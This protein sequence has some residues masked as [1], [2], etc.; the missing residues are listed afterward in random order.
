MK[1]PVFILL[2]TQSII[3]GMLKGTGRALS[4]AMMLLV[5]FFGFIIQSFSQGT[6]TF[7]SSG[8][9][10][11]P[12]GVF[13]ATVETWGGGGGGS[14]SSGSAGGGGGGGAYTKGLLTGLSAGNSISI[15]V[16]AAGAAGSPTA[17]PGN[18][19]SAT[20]GTNSIT[21]NG[22]LSVNNSRN[23]GAGG[24][25]SAVGGIIIASYAGGAGGDGR[26]FLG[27][28]EAGGGGGGSAFTNA[29]GNSG[30]NGGSS[31]NKLTPGGTGTGNGGGG[32]AYDGS[33]DAVAG[34][35]PGGGGGGRGSGG[36]TS[37]AGAAGRVVISWTVTPAYAAQFTNMNT[38]S[39]ARCAGRNQNCYS[40]SQECWDSYMDRRKP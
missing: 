9:F 8:T 19:S 33:P 21:A 29:V 27:I 11:V 20:F 2:K 5:L 38:G 16:G 10:I 3:A 7:N 23:G 25:A 35:A 28:L 4:F 24:S 12:A 15:I 34:S 1:R 14:N 13:N 37:K 18:F 39:S 40:N 31:S 22:G 30:D 32:A 17:A 26:N 36:G 6:Q